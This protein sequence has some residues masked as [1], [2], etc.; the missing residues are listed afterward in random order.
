MMGK[1]MLKCETLLDKHI[2]ISASLTKNL[3]NLTNNTHN[4]NNFY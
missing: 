1:I 2:K 3:Q 4:N